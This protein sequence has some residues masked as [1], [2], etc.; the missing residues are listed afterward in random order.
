M[1]SQANSSGE[2]YAGNLLV[3]N[4]NLY[5]ESKPSSN[6]SYAQHRP[7]GLPMYQSSYN[8]NPAST[9]QTNSMSTF[10]NSVHPP[11]FSSHLENAAFD[12]VPTPSFLVRNESSSF[13]K[14]GG[15]D[16][17]RM[18]QDE[19]PRQHCDELLQS[20]VES[21]CVGNSTPFKGVRDFGNHRD[22]GIDLNRTPDQRPAKR[23]QHTP[24]V[25]TEKFTDLL[26]LP[27]DES[28][29]LYEETQENFVTVPLDEETQ[30]RHDELLKD[31]TD[32]LS[33]SVS[34]PTPAKEVEKGSAQAVDLN[35]APELK[36]PKRRKHRPKV[37]KEEKPKKSPKPVT[38]KIPKE[39]PTGKRKYVRKKN[40]NKEAATPPANIVEIKDSSTATKTKSCR[41]VIHFEMEK[42]GDE[43][44]E[45][46]PDEKYMQE[47]NMG[48]LCFTTRPNVPD[49]C[50]QTNGVGGTIPGV[51]ISQRLGTMAENVRPTTQ[52]NLSHMS[53]MT[54]P[55]TSQS[56]REAA[57]GLLNKLASNTAG[58]LINVRR[59]LDQGKTDRYQNGFSSG[60]TH[61]QQQNHNYYKELMGM[62]SE[63]S[64]TVPNHQSNINEPRGLKRGRPPAT[65]PTQSCSI[66][67]L[68]SSVLSQ[69]VSQTGEF[70]RQSSSVNIG[71]LEI[72]AKKFESGL[73]ATLYKRYSTIQANEGCTSHLNTSGRNPINSGGFTAEM[74]QAMLNGHI[75]SEQSTNRQNNW[76]KEIIGERPIPSIVHEN[77]FQR[78]QF[79]QNLHPQFDRT[80]GTTGSNKVPSYRSLITGDKCNVPQPFPHPKA[81]DQRYAQA[82]QPMISGSLATNQVQKQGYSFSFHQVPDKKTGVLENEIIRKMK[83]LKLNDDKGTTRTEQNAIVPYKGN[84]AVVPYVESEHLRKR[85][86]RPKVDLDP[87]SE[88]IWNLLMGK[89]GSEGIENHEKGKEKWWEEE[90]KVF[91]GRADSFIARM[92]LVQG[93]RTFSRWKGSVVDSVIGVFLTQNVSDHLSSS[94]FMSLAARFPIKSTRNVRTQVQVQTSIVANESAACILYSA[95]S[96]KWEAR[97][98]PQ[99]RF[100]MPQTSINHQN[101][102]VNS[103]TQNQG[104]N[105]GTA[106][107]FTEEGSQVVEE[108]V[109]SSQDSFDSTITQGTGGARS[110][111]GSNS[112]AEEPIVSYYSSSTHCSNFTEIK[113]VETTTIEQN[114]FSDL[115]RT[116][117]GKQESLIS[118]WNELDNLN[119]HSLTN[120]LV[121]IENQHKQE[122]VAPSN[123]QLH[124]TPDCGVV[125]VEGREA[126]SEESTSSGPSIVS[127]CS[128]EKNMTCH[129]LNIRGLK[130][131]LDK[132]CAEEIG[133]ARSQKTT[134]EHSESVGEHSVH[135]QGNAIQL[136]PHCE[137]KLHE[138]YEPCKRIKT[139]PLGSASV[140]NPHQELDA[141]AKMQKNGLSNPVH[142]PAHTEK[143]LDAVDRTPGKGNQINFSNNEVHSLSKANNGG[144]VSTSKPKRRK[145]NSEKNSTFD[146]DS[147]RKQVEANGLLKERSKDAMDSID[148]EAIRLASIHEI[149][150]SIKERG[151]NNMLAERMK[152]FLNRLMKDH[153]SIDLEWLRDVP[154]DKAKD[155]LLSIRGLGLKS[156]ECV[157]LLTL[158]HLAFPV[159]TNVGRIAVRLGW[160]PLQPLPESLQLHLLELYPMLETIQKYLWPRLCKLDQRTLYEL[161]YQLITFGKVFCTKSKPNCNACP[162]RGECK[163]FASAFASARLALPAPEEKRIVPST[164]PVATEKQPALFT[165]PLPILAPE[166]ST[167]TGNTMRTSNCEPIIEVPA[168]P[169]PEPNEIITESDIE[170]AYYEDP[171]A[172]EIPTIKLSMEEFRTTLQNFIPEEDMSRAL[173]A[174]NPEAAR[175]PMPKLKN[176]SRLR[177]EHQVYELPDSHPLL[178]KMDRREPDDP[179]PYLLAIWTP[180]ETANSIQPPQSCG[181]QDPNRLCNDATCYTCSCRREANSQTVRGTI[182]IPC[183][184]AMRGSFPLNGTYF[185][186]NEMFADHESSSK[187]I[188]VPRK[189]LWNLPR[190]TVYFGTSV[191]TIFRGLVTEEIQLCFWRGFV[192][193]RGFDRKTRAPRPL[194]ARLHFPASKL[195]KMKNENT[196]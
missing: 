194:I 39:T 134:M 102:G 76:T 96:I 147:L 132:T 74:R 159:D 2:F 148:Y 10:N 47:E 100:E 154:P 26:N 55:L 54:T 145:V 140:T 146:W 138:N 133:Q 35:K 112:E 103:G 158:H 7:Y 13:R 70:Y 98:L 119:G 152:E 21:S 36:T 160:V 193:V 116:T 162:M 50:S 130:R 68:D 111:S 62:N 99:P 1:N 87:E 93:D 120:F 91:R 24:M 122:P 95:N 175:I 72:P 110:C 181:S 11:P 85:K 45:K 157:R 168:S 166:A 88:R 67:T 187:P 143:L 136:G 78:Q 155:Y 18:L 57:G 79:S 173:V 105:S 150:S 37:I 52:S 59:I 51:H 23:R 167:S 9:T 41:R 126:F 84:G 58:D 29:R 20:I 196:E 22:L 82:Y 121:N 189:W 97:L 178:Q 115:N 176:V 40:I 107:F 83:G 32:T 6:N 31:L 5:P 161:H 46:K 123:N 179:S 114:S 185:Q 117:D 17:I 101:Q 65:Q 165:R 80:C 149:S 71:S 12:Y 137:Y 104:V 15:D 81:S 77:N 38:P 183:R 89:E 135:L 25:Y 172:D 42:T 90:R 63:Y 8:L 27:L 43:E 191:S 73:Y 92:H 30:K 118:E 86:T 124:L 61:V 151:M 156:V 60:F 144:N 33:A 69:G 34:E 94:A 195:A 56:E 186:V 163:H 188:D 141:S 129:S 174:L 127:G 3:R 171:D 109:I 4:Q 75:R 142:V 180:G 128:T 153:G 108:E 53:H 19:T 14:D 66:A 169:E 190:R 64:Q 16:F 44:P 170:D 184:T 49:F 106:N 139:S 177:T 131:T 125:E 28:L 164:N 48:N 113:Q 192:C 182:L